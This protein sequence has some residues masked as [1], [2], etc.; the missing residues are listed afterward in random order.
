MNAPERLETLVLPRPAPKTHPALSPDP[1]PRP[2]AEG[3]VEAIQT[4][5]DGQ[6]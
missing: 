3:L 1:R 2:R 4:W 6:L 5:L